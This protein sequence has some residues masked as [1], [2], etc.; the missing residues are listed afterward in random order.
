MLGRGTKLLQNPLLDPAASIPWHL[1][2]ILVLAGPL[3]LLAG[4]HLAALG[5]GSAGPAA[6]A[7]DGLGVGLLAATV[8]VPAAGSFRA[9][10]LALLLVLLAAALWQ[11]STPRRRA[12]ARCGTTPVI[13]LRGWAADRD[14][15][16][17]GARAGVR[18]AV[19]CGPAMVATALTHDVALMAAVTLLLVT[20][21]ARG[22]NPH[23][24]AGRPREA[25]GLVACA[26]LAALANGLGWPL[27]N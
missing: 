13:A 4:R 10:Q 27:F 19:T 23:R 5:H 25:W 14:G 6:S 15:L 24:R 1:L 20:E 16:L 9:A 7:R 21:R 26:A 22:P 11:V 3:A 17:A 12:L 18:C 8:A 2:V